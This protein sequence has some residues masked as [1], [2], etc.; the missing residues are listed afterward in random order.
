M[1]IQRL[2][3]VEYLKTN[4]LIIVKKKTTKIIFLILKLKQQFL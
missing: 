3:F 2:K 4:L 1:S